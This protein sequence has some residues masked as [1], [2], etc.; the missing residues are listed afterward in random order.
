MTA[1]TQELYVQCL[2]RLNEICREQH[3][4]I[5]APTRLI[6]DYELGLL[7]AMQ[8]CFPTGR[9]RGCWFHSATVSDIYSILYQSYFIANCCY[10]LLL[11]RQC[12]GTPVL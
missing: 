10:T 12:S 7:Q 1:R 9:A 5:P 4:R 2:T 6:A 8:S 11:H 3:G